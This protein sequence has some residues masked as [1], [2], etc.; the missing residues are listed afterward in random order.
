MIKK[1]GYRGFNSKENKASI[2]YKALNKI[3]FFYIY[4]SLG[5]GIF[6]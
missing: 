5:G 2:A 1:E 6:K 4:I 3:G